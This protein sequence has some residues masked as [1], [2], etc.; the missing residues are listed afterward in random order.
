MHVASVLAALA[1]T[2]VLFPFAAA[3]C[4]NTYGSD[5]PNLNAP[6]TKIVPNEKYVGKIGEGELQ[7]LYIDIVDDLVDVFMTVNATSENGDVDVY[8]SS[9]SLFPRGEADYDEMEANWCVDYSCCEWKGELF[10][11]EPMI[12][13][14]HDDSRTVGGTK[15]FTNGTYTLMMYGYVETEYTV[16]FYLQI[17]SILCR[18]ED[19][20]IHEA[21]C[22]ALEHLYSDCQ[23]G[24]W[25]TNWLAPGTDPCRN[26]TQWDGVICNSTDAGA[27]VYS[28]DLSGF[29]VSDC[30][31]RD[32]FTGLAG[33]IYLNLSH[34]GIMKEIPPGIWSFSSL[35]KLDLSFNQFE[36][37][38]PSI[39]ALSTNVS[40]IDISHNYLSGQLLGKSRNPETSLFRQFPTVTHLDV[41]WNRFSGTIPPDVAVMTNLTFLD[42]SGNSLDGYIPTEISTLRHL[43]VLG[44]GHNH[45]AGLV[46]YWVHNLTLLDVFDIENNAFSGPIP[47]PIVNS[48]VIR[49]LRIGGNDISG[50]IPESLYSYTELID[51]GINNNR[52]TG[53][54]SETLGRL[55]KLKVF[56]AQHNQLSGNL[57][58]ALGALSTLVDVDLSDNLFSGALPSSLTLWKQNITNFS[59][60]S[61]FIRGSLPSNIHEWK[62]LKRLNC[63]S[64][65]LSA[66][67]SEDFWAVPSLEYVNL[68]YN[69]F[70]GSL[71][72]SLGPRLRKVLISFNRFNGTFP[73]HLSVSSSL[74]YLHFED[75]FISGPL[76]A[77]LG[78]T[79]LRSL[80][81][82]FNNLDG[83]IPDSIRYLSR[84]LEY[85]DLQSN[86][87][88]GN[89]S[90]ALV[91][92]YALKNCIIQNNRLRGRLSSSNGFFP[93]PDRGSKFF[94]NV[95]YFVV[96][97]ND[98]YGTFPQDFLSASTSLLVLQ[99]GFN[100][101][102]G[103]IEREFVATQLQSIDL[104]N[105]VLNG[106]IHAQFATNSLVRISL[107]NNLFSG[108]IPQSF[109]AL[110]GLE[111]V[112]F[113]NMQLSGSVPQS[114]Y[115][116][117]FDLKRLFLQQNRFSGPILPAVSN[118]A[119]TLLELDISQNLLT[120]TAFPVELFE[121]PVLTNLW[122]SSNN[123][124]IESAQWNEKFSLPS[125]R[126]L[127]LADNSIRGSFPTAFAQGIP[128][129]AILD[130]H[131][132]LFSGDLDSLF[133]LRH[134]EY[135]DL[136]QNAFTEALP[137]S[138]SSNG[139]AP[140]WYVD[141]SRNS[142][143]GSLAAL[144][145]YVNLTVLSVEVNRFTSLN[146]GPKHLL[147]DINIADNLFEESLGEVLQN[148][149]QIRSTVLKNNIPSHSFRSPGLV[150]PNIEWLKLSDSDIA[151][152]V[153]DFH[154]PNLC[155]VV[156]S[157]GL[158]SGV[159]PDTFLSPDLMYLSVSHNQL[160]GSFPSG[161]ARSNALLF[162]DLSHNGLDV[163]SPN[164]ASAT[165]PHL[166]YL[167]L[168]FNSIR[169]KIPSPFF[170]LPKIEELILEENKIFQPF[171]AS[172]S[173]LQTLLYLD[174][175]S[176]YFNESIPEDIGLLHNLVYLDLSFNN[177]SASVPQFFENVTYKV[178]LTANI[179]RCPLPLFE[180]VRNTTTCRC[181]DGSFT[182]S[183]Y[184]TCAQCMPG[185][186]SESEN[187]LR[188]CSPC[189]KG[190]FQDLP[191]QSS[192]L[193]C[194][195]GN[196]ADVLG[197]T[198]CST[199]DFGTAASN[200]GSEVC[201]DCAL[202]TFSRFRGAHLCV[203]CPPGTVSLPKSDH[204][205]AC[206][207]NTY[208]A[209][210]G[211]RKCVACPSGT[212]TVNMAGKSLEDCRCKGG[213]I[214]P[215]GGPCFSW[216]L[217]VPLLL[218]V[219]LIILLPLLLGA[220]LA[221]RS[222]KP[223]IDELL[224]DEK[225]Q[226]EIAQQK[227]QK[228]SK[229]FNKG[230]TKARKQSHFVSLLK[231]SQEMTTGRT[232]ARPSVAPAGAL[233]RST[234]SR[235]TSSQGQHWSSGPGSFSRN[236]GLFSSNSEEAPS[237]IAYAL[238]DDVVA[239]DLESAAASGSRQE[240]SIA[241]RRQ[242]ARKMS[243][244]WKQAM[245]GQSRIR[246]KSLKQAKKDARS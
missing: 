80:N 204:C 231:T 109:S 101:I 108:T 47:D 56:H 194:A 61:N 40:V 202:G 67:I 18:T 159:V 46:P 242:Q 121:M 225:N 163:F 99:G 33:L 164:L 213:L 141:V 151:D 82:A 63:E 243:I 30:Q 42:F 223:V 41:S 174:A 210:G 1:L 83:G 201:A 188:E 196:Y 92:Q 77:D 199:C 142:F 102:S 177:I 195:K 228:L 241:E 32:S 94:S 235:Y 45:L 55:R 237:N 226:M 131:S 111:D 212:E 215:P 240:M 154:T 216:S 169:L 147:R 72:S 186:Y 166:R 38:L 97:N 5:Y 73:L 21:D 59:F 50:P 100:L 106:T 36:G 217:L 69:D 220:E 157:S 76:S 138:A 6:R 13:L 206:Q 78:S 187:S 149:P 2:C 52:L 125:L 48:S 23:G 117:N 34:N 95:E 28:L 207:R 11:S 66:K 120:G 113:S 143:T 224:A 191:S 179:F 105:N 17:N 115:T 168:S 25:D 136:S 183:L 86:R 171:P 137:A 4:R 96:F 44:F 158:V 146:L 93:V 37:E 185:S 144:Q 60:R 84:T 139:T 91:S 3:V 98:I 71:P 132:N 79:K 62:S 192:C 167:D 12:I 203:D 209:S 134:L 227:M 234:G 31:L 173:Q 182:T 129:L 90:T 230:V 87:L 107:A 9:R 145:K 178:D 10:G 133:K 193:R 246:K 190:L 229:K 155:G 65:Y 8:I 22:Y 161:I 175:S 112:D 123:F 156:S 135:L 208:V 39:Y 49:K 127:D 236:R 54:L 53:P 172:F 150:L 114:L 88:Y 222:A 126:E 118:L 233:A 116:D 198:T 165:F 75:N 26:G 184:A 110:Y 189:P 221:S 35:D 153:F 51:L 19:K 124:L 170:A 14:R 15:M 162:A 140:I 232:N 245:E 180:S 130:I 20:I 152:N 57:P 29:G 64:N 244:Q 219:C 160:G 200:E 128:N 43:T 218:I 89:F 211:P 148:F 214:G 197:S 74:Q 205:T 239:A 176:N 85:L 119:A 103:T 16:F 122:L 238:D 7:Y 58:A 27:R 81:A 70:T 68:Q 181:P 24:K 104:A